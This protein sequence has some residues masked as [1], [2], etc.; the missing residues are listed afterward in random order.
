M[1]RTFT[2]FSQGFVLAA[3][4][5][6]AT[7]AAPVQAQFK[8]Y[9]KPGLGAGIKV[10]GLI[11]GTELDGNV[12]F[13]VRAYLNHGITE[14]L[15]LEVGGGYAAIS[16]K[17]DLAAIDPVTGLQSVKHDEFRTDLAV[18]DA[19]AYYTPYTFKHWSPFVYGG[20]GALRYDLDQPR[21]STQR[22]ANVKGIDWATIVPVGVG[23][24]IR[25]TERIFTDATAG[26]TWTSTD[27]IDGV[28]GGDKDDI[29]FGIKLG[30]E[31]GTDPDPDRDRLYN[32][33]EQRLG[34]KPRKYDS[35]NDGLSDGDEVRKHKTN[36]LMAD[37][38]GDGLS[39][40]DE[41][42]IHDTD[43]L[44]ADSDGDGL[45]DGDEVQLYRTKP[46]VA[47]TDGDGLSDG[48]EVKKYK[49]KPRMADSDADGLSDG[50]EVNKH[51]TN[52][53]LWDTDGDGISDGAEVAKGTNPLVA[54]KPAP[55]PKPLVLKSI[56][57]GFSGNALSDEAR[58]ALDELAAQLKL[59]PSIKLEV[60]G[61]SNDSGARG[62]KLS[63][64]RA[65]A[66]V[67]YLVSKGIDKS[68][69]NAQGMG[70]AHLMAST[71]TPEGRQQNRRV[72]FKINQ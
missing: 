31:L 68:R 25:L 30:L 48:D 5:A 47:D 64:D 69:L 45:S 72:D 20:V 28:A 8:N 62:K 37:T 67:A 61:Y 53:L 29:Y 49:T 2:F 15:T 24:K 50:D 36:P 51:K 19:R 35:D 6:L 16:G 1:R 27:L 71:R 54:E 41:V 12:D 56:P 60:L 57:F 7:V 70:A 13:Q 10:G 46:L 26:Y 40:G 66:V 39:D 38:D 52:P 14:K 63:T 3:L 58:T 4:V 65:D 44:K 32:K 23:A 11:G 34:T 22:T 42:N 33:V 55:T 43:P 21:I 17:A 9:G 59:R 18:V